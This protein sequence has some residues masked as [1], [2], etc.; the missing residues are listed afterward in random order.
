MERA[1]YM[2]GAFF[3]CVRRTGTTGGLRRPRVLL[4]DR[5]QRP[6]SCPDGGVVCVVG[7]LRGLSGQSNRAVLGSTSHNGD[8]LPPSAQAKGLF[9]VP[10]IFLL[11]VLCRTPPTSA[12][13]TLLSSN[14]RS[15]RTSEGRQQIDRSARKPSSS[16][17]RHDPVPRRGRPSTDYPHHESQ[18]IVRQ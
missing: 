13:P 12:P 16:C 17:R 2:S 9:I 6:V 8:P 3:R 11:D 4:S 7:P 10:C 1:D 15:E 5:A 18:W 14:A